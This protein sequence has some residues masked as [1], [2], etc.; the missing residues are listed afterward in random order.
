MLETPESIQ[1][2]SEQLAAKLFPN[3]LPHKDQK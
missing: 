3:G 2:L 1:T